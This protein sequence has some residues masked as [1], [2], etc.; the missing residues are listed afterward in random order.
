M[1]SRDFSF[2]GFT[3]YPFPYVPFSQSSSILSHVQQAGQMAPCARL[4][5][6]KAHSKPVKTFGTAFLE[7]PGKPGIQKSVELPWPHDGNR[8]FPGSAPKHTHREDWW[9]HVPTQHRRQ[10]LSALWEPSPT[11]NHENHPDMGYNKLSA[12]WQSRAQQQWRSHLS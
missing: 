4:G 6:A 1:V 2:L 7:L 10:P 9:N 8:T 11:V 3:S 5:A 12:C